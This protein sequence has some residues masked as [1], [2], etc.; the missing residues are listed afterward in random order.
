MSKPLLGLL[1]GGFLGAF[2][3]WSAL[4][5]AG[6]DPAVR[7]D[8]AFIVSMG[9]FKG[10][11]A[12]VVIGWF[13]RRFQAPALGI[14]VGLTLGVALAAPIAIMQG[15]YYWQIMLPGGIVGLLVGVAT[16]LYGGRPASAPSAA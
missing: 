14:L 16:Q 13:A 4:W 3:G 1:L 5:T 15:K 6:D 7:R 9:V 11:V 8:I 10:A 12:G 2:D